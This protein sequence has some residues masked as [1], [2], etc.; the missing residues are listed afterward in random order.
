MIPF[1]KDPETEFLWR[2]RSWAG[3]AKSAGE[4]H[5][6]TTSGCQGLVGLLA[7]LPLLA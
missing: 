3:E 5:L 6:S 1:P 4:G 2:I 7:R